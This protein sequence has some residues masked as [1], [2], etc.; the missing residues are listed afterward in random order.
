MSLLIMQNSIEEHVR[1]GI[2]SYD[3]A[4]AYLDK[5]E[6]RFKRSDK[7]KTGVL[8]S[9][10]INTKHDGSGSVREHLLKLVNLANKLNA[11]DIS[12]IDQFLVHMAFYSLSMIMSS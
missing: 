9:A 1:G 2:L 10:F 12:I 11:M 6:E 7:A 5:I 8:L 4:K 3:L